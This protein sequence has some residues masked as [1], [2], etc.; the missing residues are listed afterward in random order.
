[1]VPT[2]LFLA[3]LVSPPAPRAGDVVGVVKNV[4]GSAA[5]IR[6]GLSLPARPAAKIMV[7]DV[8]ETGPE[9]SLGVIMR[10]DATLS[11]GPGS[12]LVIEKFLFVPV[13]G[14]MGFL[15]RVA[16]GTLAYLAGII[17]RLAPQS[18]SFET[19]VATIGIRGT[20]FAVKVE[21]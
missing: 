17:A 14:K 7:G 4:G 20:R 15:V 13:D 12:R 2:L 1:M 18:V 10:D 3:V 6:D 5:I 8:L 9:S 19:P 11:L 21:G 16:K